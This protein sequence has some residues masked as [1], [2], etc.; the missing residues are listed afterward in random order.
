MALG[1]SITQR[2]GRPRRQTRCLRLPPP[3]LVGVAGLSSQRPRFILP[4]AVRQVEV[5]RVKRGRSLPRHSLLRVGHHCQAV[6]AGRRVAKEALRRIKDGL[7][8][9]TRRQMLRRP[10]PETPGRRHRQAAVAGHS[11]AE[12]ET[13]AGHRAAKGAERRTRGLSKQ[14]RRM[15]RR[16]QPA[17]VNTKKR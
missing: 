5:A 1:I 9:Q 2:S 8:K 13:K 15:L 3:L 12:V 17:P 6:A 7:S 16:P 14:T 11:R 4:I 10:Q